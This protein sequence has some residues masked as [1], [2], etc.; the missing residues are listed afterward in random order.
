MTEE[1]VIHIVLINR[2]HDKNQKVN[3][4]VPDGYLPVTMWKIE[5]DDINAANSENERENISPQMVNLSRKFLN[6]AVTI[7][8]CEFIMVRYEK[9]K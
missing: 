4:K 8:P 1:G 6:S 5:N 3:I 2:S 9:N 7:S